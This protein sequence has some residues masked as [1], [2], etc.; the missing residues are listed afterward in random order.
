MRR[1]I[2]LFCM[3][4]FIVSSCLAY[5]TP[6]DAARMGYPVT[7]KEGR[8]GEVFDAKDATTARGSANRDQSDS[9]SPDRDSGPPATRPTPPATGNNPF[10]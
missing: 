5:V 3:I 10:E 2:L 8:T 4:F 1:G 7:R 9:P 6:E